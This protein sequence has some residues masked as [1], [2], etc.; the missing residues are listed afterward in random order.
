MDELLND[1]N[2]PQK[3][4]VLHTEGPLLV[5]AGAG[6]GKT[7]VITY[8]IANLLNKGVEPYN[9]LAITFTNKAAGE[10]KKRVA[11]L[12]GEK[13]A[14]VWLSTF[15]SFAAKVL[16]MEARHINLNPNYVI[17]DDADQKNI[18]KQCIK[19]LSID[20]KKFKIGSIQDAISRAK[21]DLIDSVS[22]SIYT[23]TDNDKMRYM[24]SSV[25]QLY[26]NKLNSCN[27][28][29][30]GD[31]LLKLMETFMNYPAIREK[32]QAR[33]HY[34]LV[35]EYQDTNRAQYMLV[36]TLAGKHH[37]L[38]VV[39]DDDQ[40]IYSWRGANVRNI[41][42]FEKD[43]PE[44]KI[45]KLEQNYRSTKAILDCSW[46]VIKN[47]SS[48][49]E[50]RLW[51]HKSTEENVRLLSFSDEL[52]EAKFI[53]R[54]IKRQHSSE[55]K[56]YDGF[57]VFYRTNAQ[58]RVFE[59]AFRQE[60][61][62]YNIVGT[63]KFY[64]RKEIKDII[65]YLRVIINPNDNLSLKRIINV[66]HR[67]IGDTTIKTFEEL[68]AKD[69]ISLWEALARLEEFDIMPR[70]K[71]SA[72]EFVALIKRF[73]VQLAELTGPEL[74]QAVLKESG[75]LAEL[76]LEDSVYSKER[77]NNLMEFISA[78]QEYNEQNNGGKIEDFLANVA[79]MSDLDTLEARQD[80]SKVT[81]MTLHLAKGLEFD[82]VFVTGLEEGLF[83]IAS[84]IMEDDLD[85]ER[86]LCYVGMTR[87]KNSL[88][89]THAESRRLYGQL[90]FNAPSR[91]IHEAHLSTE[92]AIMNKPAQVQQAFRQDEKGQNR[93]K[94]YRRG[95]R[96]KHPEFG[97]GRIV[98]I[99]GDE[100]DLKVTVIFE[101]GD[102]KK[103]LVKYANLHAF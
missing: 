81:I 54:E 4:A 35:D 76:E 21:D 39:G 25:Y 42:D 8:R 93:N 32:Y 31:L 17:Y 16:R 63:L 26:Q 80:I 96:V 12:S 36:K 71:K 102:M 84:S 2:P 61:I 55:N 19:E 66:P 95:Q 99:S 59:D 60:A 33:F 23:I 53:A 51:T 67:S 72:A 48:R 7:R 45:I 69:S 78:V 49:K 92:P 14:G 101:N 52:E 74:V 87:A 30:F 20:E 56:P 98:T 94:F 28:L 13:A 103:L 11:T 88:F 83:P 40:A 91:F 65:S 44:V 22:Y 37:N 9:I 15:H 47:N 62:P 46:N 90:R 1:L 34:V 89:L 79:L 6:T 50:K 57:S 58:S 100:D 18:I 75:Y 41:L 77:I 24:I 10:I 27:A 73:T 70:S 43:Y 29:D 97:N 64:D 82:T 85:E 68:A 38:C 86:R 5:L 3:E